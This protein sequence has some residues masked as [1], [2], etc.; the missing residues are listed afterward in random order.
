MLNRANISFEEKH[1][2]IKLY[3]IYLNIRNKHRI[4]IKIVMYITQDGINIYLQNKCINV[5][6]IN[7]KLDSLILYNLLNK[8]DVALMRNICDDEGY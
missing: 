6:M 8:C 2:K 7:E 4:V 5:I 3:L 1:E